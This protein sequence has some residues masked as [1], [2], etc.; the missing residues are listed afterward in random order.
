MI[1]RHSNNFTINPTFPISFLS[2]FSYHVILFITSI[3]SLYFF[4]SLG[5]YTD[6]VSIK[7]FC[8]Q[9]LLISIT[10]LTSIISFYMYIQLITSY[11]VSRLTYLF[12]YFF[13]LMYI[14]HLKV[15]IFLVQTHFCAFGNINYFI[16]LTY[17]FQKIAYKIIIIIYYNPTHIFLFNK[18]KIHF[19]KVKDEKLIIKIIYIFSLYVCVHV[20]H[21][22]YEHHPVCVK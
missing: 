20:S 6:W 1:H 17:A 9:L 22:K 12:F 14:F 15:H 5:V 8:I 10:H 4:F 19:A 13:P 11:R 3:S 2:L 21:K 7:H 16:L 18:Y